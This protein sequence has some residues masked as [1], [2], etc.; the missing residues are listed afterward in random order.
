MKNNQGIGEYWSYE[1]MDSP[2]G[3]AHRSFEAAEKCGMSLTCAARRG[4]KFGHPVSSEYLKQDDFADVL[5]DIKRHT[6]SR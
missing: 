6:Y 3:H 1:P 4:V 5:A 2:C